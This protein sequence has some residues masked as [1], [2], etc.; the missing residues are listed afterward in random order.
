[1][2]KQSEG[3][4]NI[5]AISK[6]LGIQPGTLRAWERRYKM[7]APVRNESGHR[8]YS[9]EHLRVLKWLVGKVEQGFTISQAVSLL[10]KQGLTEETDTAS[11]TGNRVDDLTEEL[12]QSLLNFDETKAHQL[13]N[14]AFSMYTIDKVVI[15]VLGTLLVR[16]GDLWEH[17]QITTAH[18]HFATAVLR[19]RISNLMQTFPHNGLLPKVIAVCGPNEHHELG[20]L[21]FTLYVRRKGFEVIYLGSSIKEEDMEVVIDTVKPRFLFLSCTMRENIDQTLGVIDQL[22]KTKD[23]VHVGIGGLAVN[24]LPQRIKEAYKENLVGS[25]REDWDTWLKTNL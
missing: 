10:D 16:I 1:M 25:S 22:Q 5:K 6:M 12:M 23:F 21:M 19:A 20:L 2:T 15:D 17:N 24:S 11:P 8:L 7:I 13:M 18:E 4:Y 3:K 9:E 14:R